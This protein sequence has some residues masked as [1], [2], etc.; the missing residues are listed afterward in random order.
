MNTAFIDFAKLLQSLHGGYEFLMTVKSV[1]IEENR[2]SFTVTKSQNYAYLYEK[3]DALLNEMFSEKE[4]RSIYYHE[5]VH[6]LRLMPYKIRKNEQMAVV[7]FAG[8]IMVMDD[9]MKRFGE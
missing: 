6:W 5:I 4:V 3:Y 9:I 1:A 7:F 2:I 8:M